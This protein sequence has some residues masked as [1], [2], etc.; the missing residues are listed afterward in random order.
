VFLQCEARQAE[1]LAVGLAL[2]AAPALVH[3]VYLQ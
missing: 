2:D 1:H 3:L